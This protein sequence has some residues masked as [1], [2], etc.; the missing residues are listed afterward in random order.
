[1][2]LLLI[3]DEPKLT[4]HIKQGLEEHGFTTDI[5]LNGLDG[6]NKVH[7]ENYATIILDINLPEKN[8]LEICR[9]LRKEK[10]ET[11]V[12]MLTARGTTENKVNGFEAGADDY[13]VKPF[14]FAELLARVKALTKRSASSTSQSQLLSYADVLLNKQTKSAQRKG[15]TIE[16][17]AKEF[18]LLKYFLE[19]PERVI[20]RQE[21]AEKVWDIKFDTGTNV[22]DVFVNYLRKKIDKDYA[23]KLIHTKVGFGYIFQSLKK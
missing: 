8:G 6:W 1:M 19:N 3:E 2:K 21:L 5:A 10:N 14:E 11:P 4:A 15:K 16:L 13:L 22:I 9:D 17:T 12:L 20:S 18:L 23:D 7:V